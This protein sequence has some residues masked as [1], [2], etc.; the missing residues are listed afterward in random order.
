MIIKK[1]KG[2]YFNN[3]VHKMRMKKISKY[4]LVLLDYQAVENLHYQNIYLNN[5]KK[6]GLKLK[7]LT[8]MYLKKKQK[9]KKN[10]QKKK[11]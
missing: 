8:V 2:K 10:F 3:V 9:Q 6:K 11:F 4:Y 5:L 1:L 7:K